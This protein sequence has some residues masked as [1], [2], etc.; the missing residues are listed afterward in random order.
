MFTV[1]HIIHRANLETKI[2]RAWLKKA[3]DLGLHTSS[4]NF[5][6]SLSTVVNR[7]VIKYRFKCFSAPGSEFDSTLSEA[8]G[9]VFYV[10]L[11]QRK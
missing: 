11:R 5:N 2:I 1:I 3:S 8:I 4:L 9:Q 6:V 7:D 10:R